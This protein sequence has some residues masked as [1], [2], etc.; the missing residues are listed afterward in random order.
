MIVVIIKTVVLTL[1][2]LAVLLM[3]FCRKYDF[4]IWEKGKINGLCISYHMYVYDRFMHL[5][6]TNDTD[7][8]S[9]IELDFEDNIIRI[10]TEDSPEILAY[11]FS[12][13]KVT[14]EGMKIEFMFK[15]GYEIESARLEL[16]PFH[17]SFKHLEIQTKKCESMLKYYC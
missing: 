16:E 2:I 5:V 4:C 17:K 6:N 8:R 9:R 12:K 3:F 10:E 13:Y 15:D 1:C 14:D 11:T 7:Y